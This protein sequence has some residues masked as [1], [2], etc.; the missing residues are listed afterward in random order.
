MPKPAMCYYTII[1][2]VQVFSRIGLKLRFHRHEPAE[3]A[4]IITA[5]VTSWGT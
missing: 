4:V 3:S 1:D 2:D 5:F